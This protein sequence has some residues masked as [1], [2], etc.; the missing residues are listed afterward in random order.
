VGS[1]S[2]LLRNDPAR[3]DIEL[4]KIGTTLDNW[5]K[6]AEVDPEAGPIMA[7]LK[8]KEAKQRFAVEWFGDEGHPQPEDRTRRPVARFDG[9]IVYGDPT[10]DWKLPRLED[11]S[12]VEHELVD[13]PLDDPGH[14]PGE[15]TETAILHSIRGKGASKFHRLT[16]EATTRIRVLHTKGAFR[17]KDGRL[18]VKDS[19][20]SRWRRARPTEP[21][22]PLEDAWGVK[23]RAHRK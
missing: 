19:P 1:W 6:D 4:A 17:E 13:D 20:G 9:H 7:R 10:P 12:V 5:V 23:R 22:V 11:K 15:W 16:E 21:L 2:D 3:L 18:W 8:S 14:P